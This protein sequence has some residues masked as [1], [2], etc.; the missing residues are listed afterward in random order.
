MRVVLR[1]RHRGTE[2][3]AHPGDVVT[4]GS[5]PDATLTVIHPGVSRRHGRVAFEDGAWRYRDDGST[6]GSFSGGAR[7]E[8]TVIEGPSTILLGH[9]TDGEPIDLGPESG[10]VA[11]DSAMPA[12][13]RIEIALW[14]IAGAAVA[15]VILGIVALLV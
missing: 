11:R 12:L 15:G 8:H 3:V 7:I 5:D 13:R 2:V 6:N 4:I 10:T 9:A 14:L 1:V